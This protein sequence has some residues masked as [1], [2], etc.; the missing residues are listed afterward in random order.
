MKILKMNILNWKV[1]IFLLFL[2]FSTLEYTNSVTLSVYSSRPSTDIQRD[3][4]GS[5]CP[6]KCRCVSVNQRESRDIL[7][8]FD[9]GSSWRRGSHR[10]LRPYGSGSD[11]GRSMV[12]QGLQRL[13]KPMPSDIF[14]LTIFGDSSGSSTRPTLSPGQQSDDRTLLPNTQIRYIERDVFAN[15]HFLHE[16]TLSGNNIGVLYPHVFNRLGNL[17]KLSLPNNNIRHLSSA[18]FRG[19]QSL[20]ELDLSD[21]VIYRLPPSVFEYI[22]NIKSLN[23]NGNKLQRL[24]RNQFRTLV[25]LQRLDLSRNN[26]TTFYDDTFDRNVRLQE[27]ML[28]GNR[29]SDIQSRWFNNLRA[30]K[31]LS[32]RGNMISSIRG[33]SF[34]NLRNLEELLLSANVID[35]IEEGSLRQMNKLK[36]LDLSTNDIHEIRASLFYGLDS[37]TELFIGSNKLTS[38]GSDAFINLSTLNRLDLSRNHIENIEEGTF[39]PLLYVRYIDL[40]HNK[41]RT[42]TQNIF[43]G[44]P[45]LKEL[46]LQHNFIGRIEQ[47]A[48]STTSPLYLSKLTTLDLQYNGIKK[49][50]ADT[51]SGMPNL[52]SLKLGN[53]RLK[54]IHSLALSTLNNLQKLYLNNN[55]LKQLSTGVFRRLQSLL[56]ID[57]SNNKIKS[58][59]NEMFSGLENLED[60]NLASNSIFDIQTNVFRQTLGLVDLNLSGNRLLNFNFSLVEMLEWLSTLDIS[61]NHLLWINVPKSTRIRLKELLLSENSLH[62]IRKDV[63]KIL[64]DQSSLYVSGNPLACDCHMTWMRDS[65]VSRH[66]RVEGIDNLL[67]RFPLRNRG[68]QLMDLQI[69]ELTCAA[70]SSLKHE[71]TSLVCN[72]VPNYGISKYSARAGLKALIKKHVTVLDKNRIPQ[73]SGI[74][75]HDNWALVPG[76]AVKGLQ[77]ETVKQDLDIKV[78]RTKGLR[79]VHH[80]IRHPLG[81]IGME[82]Y[83]VALLHLEAED[84]GYPI[85]LMNVNQFDTISRI[86]LKSTFTT[87]MNGRKPWTKLKFRYGKIRPKCSNANYLC[88]KVKGK[89][90]AKKKMLL[91]GSPLYLGLAGD[92]KLAGIGTNLKGSY[93][94]DTLFIPLWTM[95]DWINKVIQE[96]DTKCPLTSQNVSSCSTINLPTESELL[97]KSSMVERH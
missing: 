67:C 61:D 6:F 32:L 97:A 77:Q 51:L 50:D 14:S 5:I 74:L 92:Y 37:L 28:S 2:L 31:I 58:L 85:C 82:Q 76:N 41:L 68:K 40:S 19:L 26:L 53:N 38:L 21:N 64:K 15:N 93:S 83:N 10:G 18:V 71:N 81:S 3:K 13:P 43:R 1:F 91:D 23:L 95:I 87:R 42:I 66:I 34:A 94:S 75:I 25:Y 20:D 88:V 49:L 24:N 36:L 72:D 8:G 12:C 55:K 63:Q 73:F 47:M 96:Y 9:T 86:V 11:S 4:D 48:F 52:K 33:D 44:L 39:S 22:Q 45:E 79:K 59:P 65:S 16:V 27:L 57:L 7:D 62:R 89:K 17:R 69:E 78:G 30:L 56:S 84:K 54:R 29:I 70:K 46:N 35:T 90:A 60:L 80:V